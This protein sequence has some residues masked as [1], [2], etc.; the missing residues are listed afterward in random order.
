MSKV[1]SDIKQ[2]LKYVEDSMVRIDLTN[3]LIIESRDNNSLTSMA[4]AEETLQLALDLKYR[5]GIAYSTLNIGYLKDFQGEKH[6]A[7]VNMEH[8]LKVFKSLNNK[9]GMGYAYKYLCWYYWGLGN[10]NK[11]LK[12]FF[13]GFSFYL[14]SE[15]FSIFIQ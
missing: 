7:L 14:E 13:I 3:Q 1:I 4:L 8:A 9:K 10:M 6:E 5:K 15:A 11:A 12:L 2:Q